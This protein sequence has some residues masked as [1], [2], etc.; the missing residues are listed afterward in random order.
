MKHILFVAATHKELK[1]AKEHYSSLRVSGIQYDFFCCGIGNINTSISLSQQLSQKQYDFIVNFWVCGYKDTAEKCI[2]ISRSV[3]APNQKEIIIPTLFHFAKLS[4]I[5]CSETVV[6]D[7]T[8]LWDEN[9]CDMESYAIEKV[10]EQFKVPRIILK[11]PID[12]IGEETRNFNYDAA[13]QTLKKNIN[14]SLLIENIQ[15]Y[16]ETIENPKD[17][18]EVFAAHYPLTFSEN[19]LFEKYYFRYEALLEKKFSVFFE[20]YKHLSKKD[21]FQTLSD[22]LENNSL[23]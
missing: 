5:Y 2:Q 22:V 17:E 12:Q 18:I 13:T 6:Y 4:S 1:T 20:K 9:Y 11:V 23:K 10:C 7:A 21:F 3:Y 8:L 15:T 16:L 14:F 19:I